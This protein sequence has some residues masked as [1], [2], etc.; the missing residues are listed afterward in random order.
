MA[1]HRFA[2]GLVAAFGALAFVAPSAQA[3]PPTA[4]F[5]GTY[6]CSNG[7]SYEVYVSE[8]SLVGYVD[9]KAVTPRAF[10]FTSMLTLVVQD[11]PYAGDVITV[12]ADS[13]VTGASNRPVNSAALNGTSTCTQAF[14]DDVEFVV[15]EEE[16]GFFGIDPKY[17]GSTVSGTEE[18][19]ITVW[20]TTNQLARR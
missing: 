3:A 10:H 17:L 19:S 12:A 15:G 16:V 2:L 14:S 8:H 1:H 5:D 4:Q 18:G 6:T 11:G 20:V 13:G 7:Q 9:G